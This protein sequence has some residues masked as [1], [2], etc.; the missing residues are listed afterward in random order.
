MF[1]YQVCGGM[2]YALSRDGKNELLQAVGKTRGNI[3][4]VPYAIYN[5]AV[6]A[7]VCR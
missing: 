4:E 6:G 1:I 7:R 5:Q 3:Y 2:R